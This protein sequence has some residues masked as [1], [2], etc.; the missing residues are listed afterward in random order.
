[1][2]VGA[3]EIVNTPAEDASDGWDK[4]IS[5]EL[6]GIKALKPVPDTNAEITIVFEGVDVNVASTSGLELIAIE[7]SSPILTRV[8]ETALET[9]EYCKPLM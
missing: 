5:L 6:A 7:S 1:M 8:L 3:P 9:N 4:V 2:E